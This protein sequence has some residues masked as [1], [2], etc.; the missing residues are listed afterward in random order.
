MDGEAADARL[1]EPLP[2]WERRTRAFATNVT[3]EAFDDPVGVFKARM[4]RRGFSAPRARAGVVF[5]DATLA[6]L[7]RLG[8]GENA[9][10]GEV[11]KAYKRRVRA[12]HPDAHGGDRR[13]EAELRAVIDAYTHLR[14]HPA[15]SPR[16]GK[17]RN[18]T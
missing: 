7:G 1:T 11:A 4:G 13:H 14:Q 12:L 9:S 16:R 18:D 17:D 15:F 3:G 10:W 6:A 5:D 8:L 2:G